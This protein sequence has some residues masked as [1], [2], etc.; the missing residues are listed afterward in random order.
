M[1]ISVDFR[2][3]NHWDNFKDGVQ[4]AGKGIGGFFSWASRVTSDIS[5]LDKI[6]RVGS[7][8][9]NL[10]AE[11]GYA[12]NATKGVANSFD[13]SLGV[14]DITRSASDAYYFFSGDFFEDLK[15]WN[16]DTALSKLSF[17]VS[18][19]I[20]TYLTVD[21][22][23]KAAQDLE[24]AT[25]VNTET[26]EQIGQGFAVG[27]YFFDIAQNIRTLVNSGGRDVE[28]WLDLAASIT[29]IVMP[30]LALSGV[31]CVPAFF[32]LAL[33]SC[34]F[35]L[36]SVAYKMYKEKQNNDQSLNFAESAAGLGVVLA[37]VSQTVGLLP[38]QED[39]PV[40]SELVE[41]AGA[42]RDLS[43][44]AGIF[45]RLADWFKNGFKGSNWDITSRMFATAK[46]VMDA[47]AWLNTVAL[48]EGVVNKNPI[49][50]G[51]RTVLG[52]GASAF[53][54]IDSGIKLHGNKFTKDLPKKA[55]IKHNWENI[56]K[57]LLEGP[58]PS[59]EK[60]DAL[61]A[62]LY[63]YYD[64]K[65]T[66]ESMQGAS[67][68]DNKIKEWQKLRTAIETVGL[69][70]TEPVDDRQ[71]VQL[72]DSEDS[73]ELRPTRAMSYLD[74]KQ[75]AF[76]EKLAKKYLVQSDDEISLSD[77]VKAKKDLSAWK[78]SQ[79]NVEKV[80]ISTTIA[81]ECFKVVAA[82]ANL[83]A[84]FFA[85]FLGVVPLVLNLLSAVVGAGKYFA[86]ASYKAGAEPMPSFAVPAA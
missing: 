32:A 82:V 48:I 41:E 83:A 40:L 56:A 30:I 22:M 24:E 28:A 65:I 73:G 79:L 23:L 75:K 81:S 58:L 42:L 55:L 43:G 33:L 69:V 74:L 5:S 36:A 51:V 19:G 15:N 46:S 13:K 53:K 7:Q 68:R 71:V 35:T 3:V 27:G 37:P 84:I 80:K 2:P 47:T 16:L 8:A 61:K 11:N 59:K 77:V 45:T 4:Q 9:I 12:N 14:I 86:D 66:K 17:S 21:G 78:F 44:F 64:A 50:K 6:L 34:G 38:D 62:H 63:H 39:I 54:I 26:V 57:V 70:N 76:I 67:K 25:D 20:G 10:A 18:N 52:L 49:F 29:G 85:K 1:D 31:A 60:C 72:E